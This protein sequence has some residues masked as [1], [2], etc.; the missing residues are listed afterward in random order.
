MEIM[1]NVYVILVKYDLVC[2]SDLLLLVTLLQM[3]NFFPKRFTRG[4]ILVIIG[5]VYVKG[6]WTQH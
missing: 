1:R 4:G 2:L 3:V 5:V 6:E